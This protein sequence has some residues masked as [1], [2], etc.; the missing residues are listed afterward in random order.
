MSDLSHLELNPAQLRFS[1]DSVVGDVCGTEETEPC[2]EI[3]GQERAVDAIR[4]GLQVERPG[5]N[6][7]VVGYSGTGR[8]T[9]IRKMIEQLG[10][11]S[12]DSPPDLCYV[13]NFGNPDS[14]KLLQF[15]PGIGSR[16]RDEMEKLI[17]DLR[18]TIHGLL[19]FVRSTS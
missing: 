5:Y 6:V 19:D 14:P 8:S 10:L 18:D 3:I 16:F 2:D 13:N 12:G 15:P 11:E 1:C 9:A 4:L 17:T 7:F